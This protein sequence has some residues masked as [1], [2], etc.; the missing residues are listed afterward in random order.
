MKMTV[1]ERQ[2]RAWKIRQEAEGY[3]VSGVKTLEDAENYF[4]NPKKKNAKAKAPKAPAKAKAKAPAD[5]TE[6]PIEE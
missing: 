5:G 2:L 1:K 3:D 4:K 6:E